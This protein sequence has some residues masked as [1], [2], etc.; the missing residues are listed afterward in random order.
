MHL[1]LIRHAQSLNNAQ[2]EEL[3]VEDPALTSLGR[4]QAERLGRW[5]PALQLT[6]VI[7]SPF[8]RALQTAEAIGRATALAPEVRT[9]LHETGGC[10]RGYVGTEIVGRPGMSRAEIER[11]FPGFRVAP[12]IDGQG[13][14]ACKPHETDAEA[15]LRAERLWEE[16][17][18][19]FGQTDE[20]IAL[21]LH[22]DFKVMLLR[23]FSTP[24]LATPYNT[25][26]ST[27]AVEAS[28]VRLIDYNSVRH[29]PPEFVTG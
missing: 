10:Y 19:E 5:I 8:L 9:A 7:S 1:F 17:I 24:P 11:D 22:A 29:L 28:K 2:P 14:W 16:T 4:Q 27:V 15:S 26:V 6:R 25:S 3:R 20:R 13:W 21:V 12:E 23:R 18:V